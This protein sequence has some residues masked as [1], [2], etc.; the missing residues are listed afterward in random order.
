MERPFESCEEYY[1]TQEQISRWME[2]IDED[3]YADDSD[4]RDGN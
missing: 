4:H 1:A 2:E 3:D